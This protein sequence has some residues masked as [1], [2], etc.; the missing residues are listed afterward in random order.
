M[1]RFTLLGLFSLAFSVLVFS[2]M[3]PENYAAIAILG[4]LL[5]LLAWFAKN[6]VRKNVESAPMPVWLPMS[7]ALASVVGALWPASPVIFAVWTNDDER[8]S[9]DYP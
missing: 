6:G 1:L 2:M 5:V 8:D 4:G 3:T 7:F 9:D